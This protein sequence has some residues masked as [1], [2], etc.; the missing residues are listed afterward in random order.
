MAKRARG[1]IRFGSIMTRFPTQAAII[2]RIV[3]GYGELEIAL[4]NCVHM[5]RGGDLDVVLK[6]MFGTRGEAQRISI[7]D[8]LGRQVFIGLGLDAEFANAIADMDYCRTIRNQYAHC[9]WHNDGSRRLGFVNLEEL[10]K[11]NVF[12]PNLIG[13]ITRYLDVSLLQEQETY[14]SNVEHQ[15][16]WL[17]FESQ[18][19]QGTGSQVFQTPPQLPRPDRYRP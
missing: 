15:I 17:N 11:G 12:V 6:A 19:R 7:A 14:Q 18:S 1:M 2:G 8:A 9:I 3:I 16:G 10:A 4:M 5:A 13:V